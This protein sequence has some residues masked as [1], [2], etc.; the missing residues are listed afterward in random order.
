MADAT[1]KISSIEDVGGSFRAHV[2]IRTTEF[3]E[4]TLEIEVDVATYGEV[5]KAVHLRLAALG[6]AI[7]TAAHRA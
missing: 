7:A 4:I 6:N 5:P 3:D 1:I 2:V